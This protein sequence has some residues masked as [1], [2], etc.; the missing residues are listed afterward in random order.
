MPRY[1]YMNRPVRFLL[2]SLLIHFLCPSLTSEAQLRYGFRFAGDFADASLSGAP[3]YSVVNKSGFSGGLALEYQMQSC[4]LAADIAALYTRLNYQ[5]RLPDE[6]MKSL[7]R[8]FIEVPV[9]LK[10][11]FWLKSFHELVAPM[12]YTGPSLLFRT[13]H[14]SPEPPVSNRIQP[15]WDVGIGFDIVNFIQISGGYR[16]ALGNAAGDFP[17]LPDASLHTGCWNIAATL[18]FDF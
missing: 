4:G 17:S 13:G 7:G 15:G 1:H 3:G 18:L 11:K 2:L 16:F 8:D 6:T 9:H 14:D 5:L 12:V 10:Y